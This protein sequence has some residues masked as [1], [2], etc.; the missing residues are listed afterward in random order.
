MFLH[1]V[2]ACMTDVLHPQSLHLPT[3]ECVTG[4]DTGLDTLYYEPRISMQDETEVLTHS[5]PSCTVH[6]LHLR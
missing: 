6:S 4:T 2:N 3:S 5:Y 1:A